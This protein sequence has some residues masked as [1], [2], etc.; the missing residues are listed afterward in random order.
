MRGGK[1]ENAGRK[2][3]DEENRIRTLCIN[4]LDTVFGSEEKAFNHMAKQAKNLDGRD[5]LAY[6]K[7]LIE[8]AYG[9]PKDNIDVS[10]NEINALEI[11]Q[12]LT[13]EQKLKVLGDD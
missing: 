2:S 12:S 3:K 10:E 7:V 9:K 6:L 1:R 11:W 5:A 8:Y 13:K 4:A